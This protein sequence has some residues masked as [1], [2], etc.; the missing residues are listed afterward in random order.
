MLLWKKSEHFN[1]VGLG[2]VYLFS[3]V[4]KKKSSQPQFGEA[5]KNDTGFVLCNWD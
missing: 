1:V 5:S 3:T 4:G 2:N